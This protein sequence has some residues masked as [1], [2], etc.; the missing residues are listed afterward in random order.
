MPAIHNP[1]LW[2]GRQLCPELHEV[3]FGCATVTVDLAQVNAVRLNLNLLGETILGEAKARRRLD[4]Y[5]A[6]L[7]RDHLAF[8]QTLTTVKERLR[9]LYQQALA[10]HF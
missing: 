5:V 7:G 1:G 10:R 6:L 2:F 3:V 8:D 4:G 9:L